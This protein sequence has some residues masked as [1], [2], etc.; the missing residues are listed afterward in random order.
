MSSDQKPLSSQWNQLTLKAIQC[1]N[2][3]APLAARALAMVH[4]AMYDAWSVYNKCAISTTTAQNIKVADERHCTAANK[5]KAFSYA[6]YNV[7]QHLFWCVLPAEHKNMFRGL[8]CACDYFP[9]DHSLDITTPQGIGNLMAKL[10]IEYRNGDGANEHSTLH[11]PQWSD[12]TGY[13]PVNT[14]DQVHDLSCWQPLRTKTASGELNVQHFLVPQW[15]L[16]K[17]FALQ[18]NWQFRPQP[19]FRKND[20]GF[21]VQAEEILHISECL[22]VEQKAVAEYWADER[23]TYTTPGRWFEIAQFVA[24]THDYTECQCIQLFFALGNAMLDAAIASWECK[25]Y[26]NSVRPVTVIRELFCGQELQAWGGVHKGTRTLTG[27]NWQPYIPT[28]PFPEH[29]SGHSTF[30]Y[31]AATILKQYTRSDNF[32]GCF[33]FEKGRSVIEPNTS[34]PCDVVFDWPT[35]TAAAEQAGKSGLYGG[36]HFKNAIECGQKLG[37]QV[38]LNAWDKATFYFN[39]A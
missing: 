5:Q 31:A 34:P 30:S 2:A 6:A 33:T 26:Y 35:F 21:K 9:D 19:P 39:E 29:V 1:T 8:M 12:Y 22:T 14:P 10:V 37:V 28:P 13:H 17:S 20:A 3:P 15:G 4:T 18:F 7:L 23:G 27:E 38:G 11:D 24:D 25:K 32:N 36:I 16:V